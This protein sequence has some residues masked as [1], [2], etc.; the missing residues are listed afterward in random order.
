MK[1]KF[2]KIIA[3]M[4]IL[5]II[6]GT[7]FYFEIRVPNANPYGDKSFTIAKGQGVG[8]IVKNLESQGFLEK[9]NSFKIYVWLKGYRA[10]FF[11]G[12]YD[13]R[14]DSSVKQLI[15][16]LIGQR[17]LNREAEIK[18]LE[19]WTDEDIDFYLAKQGLIQGGDF[20]KYSANY[21]GFDYP[22]LLDRTPSATLQGYLYPDTY[23]VYRQADAEAI[24]EKM[25]NNFS[26]KLTPE[27]RLEIK[28]QNKSIFEVVILA[29]I[30]E[31]EISSYV[32]RQI[33]AG[34]FQKRLKIGM[35]L[36]SDATV[37]YVTKKGAASP[38]LD[39]TKID[40]LY[41][42]YKYRSLPPGPICNPSIEAI[43]A[44]IY[45][46]Q[47]EYWYFLT[48]SDGKVYFGATYDEHLKNKYKYFKRR[49]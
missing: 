37:N 27:L 7:I 36:Q 47:T 44:V 4:A 10:K 3:I 33:V 5:L 11:D 40:S 14:T 13:L 19:G 25:L 26:A 6:F 18:I 39:D 28:K 15:D 17:D 46:E 43:R 12:V 42:T 2:I 1:I 22:F 45:P 29:S 30:V 32:N 21:N 8:D 35:A 16:A 23:R 9:P 49:G 31:K 41:N 38:S 48:T 20:I 34:I 24:A